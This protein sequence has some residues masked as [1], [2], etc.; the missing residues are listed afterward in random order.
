MKTDKVWQAITPPD[1]YSV[2]SGSSPRFESMKKE[3]ERTTD[4]YQRLVAPKSLDQIMNE[5]TLEAIA[6]HERLLAELSVCETLPDEA[7][8]FYDGHWTVD[9]VNGVTEQF[10]EGWNACL[11]S[12]RAAGN[13]CK[14]G[15]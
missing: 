4:A 3:V 13:L 2:A 14:G 10:A 7:R 15:V 1:G 11:N 6:Q 8:Y 12:I 9:G 5:I